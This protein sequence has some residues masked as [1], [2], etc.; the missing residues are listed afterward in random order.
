MSLLAC[1]FEILMITQAAP[2]QA[3]KQ[4]PSLA[5]KE[6]KLNAN[7]IGSFGQTALKEALDMVY[8]MSAKEIVIIF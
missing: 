8:E 5:P 6:L 7:Y 4:N 3:L 1:L 2:V